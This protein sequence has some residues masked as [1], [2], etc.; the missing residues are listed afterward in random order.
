MMLLF[1]SH[2]PSGARRHRENPWRSCQSSEPR[3]GPA[4]PGPIGPTLTGSSDAAPCREVGAGVFPSEVVFTV[5]SDPEHGGLAVALSTPMK[6]I[7]LRLDPDEKAR[8]EQLAA[9]RHV[10][11]SHALREGARLYLDDMSAKREP[12]S[13]RLRKSLRIAE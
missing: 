11:L 9:E 6:V 1:P 13:K 2:K 5:R 4:K 10:T 3:Q 12:D 7:A 8:L